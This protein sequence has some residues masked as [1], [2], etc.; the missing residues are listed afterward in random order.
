MVVR[1]AYGLANVGNTCSVSALV[2]CM[3]SSNSLMKALMSSYMEH[4]L[5]KNADHDDGALLTRQLIDVLMKL[6]DGGVNPTGFVRALF[7]T[8]KG[9]ISFGEQL[10]IVEIWML[11]IDHIQKELGITEQ[12]KFQM[13]DDT[14]QTRILASKQI[15]NKN[16]R[17]RFID[18]IQGTQLSVLRCRC[19]FAQG[20]IEVFTSIQVDVQESAGSVIDMLERYMKP[21]PMEHWKC[22]KCQQVG[23]G[24]K[25]VVILEPPRV[26]IVTLK[27]FRTLSNGILE[28]ITSPV[29][30]DRTF[31]INY[32]SS[33]AT[34]ALRGVGQHHGGY[35]G[36]HYTAMC[37]RGEEWHLF[38]DM[39]V[40]SLGSDPAAIRFD[41]RNCYFLVY[42][43]DMTMGHP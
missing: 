29:V 37:Q 3:R 15:Y 36:G 13:D 24:T 40:H 25:N 1:M 17:C 27:R 19:G 32:E 41:E 16:K 21:E 9:N 18:A 42:E 28:K 5:A 4:K 30:I 14:L 26:L 38:D 22:D 34:Y 20:N 43:T 12:Q 35:N 6:D 31:V 33:D 8:F 11:L 7:E 39:S 23:N 2:Q 10:D